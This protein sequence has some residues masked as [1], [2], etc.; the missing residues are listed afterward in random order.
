MPSIAGRSDDG[1]SHYGTATP[2]AWDRNVG[3]CARRPCH[4]ASYFV[5]RTRNIEGKDGSPLNEVRMLC[6]SM[7]HNHDVM[8]AD[9]TIK[10][11]PGQIRAEVRSRR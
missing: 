3:Q 11:D 8:T 7:M 2:S 9:G 6:N 1:K 5:H 10:Y 4:N